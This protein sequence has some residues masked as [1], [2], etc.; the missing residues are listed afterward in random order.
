MY[1]VRNKIYS[2]DDKIE[3]II[4]TFVN[5]VYLYDDKITITCNFRDG[6]DLKKIEIK[7]LDKFGFDDRR[8]TKE[9][10]LF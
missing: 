10:R 5:A 8:P 7:D 2:A 9:E 1:D 4:R 6:E 3:V